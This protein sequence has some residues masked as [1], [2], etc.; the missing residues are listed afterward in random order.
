MALKS[1]AGVI[2][3][4]RKA[5]VAY[6]MLLPSMAVLFAF[7]YFPVIS[8]IFHSFTEWDGYRP[9]RFIGM[10]N[11]VRMATDPNMLMS[12]RN[13]FVFSFGHLATDLI[14]SVGVALLIHELGGGRKSRF[15]QTIFIVPIMVPT[16]ITIFIWKFIYDPQFGL[17]NSLLATLGLPAQNF[18]AD[19][20]FAIL[21]L[22]FLG[23]PWIWGPGVLMQLAGLQSIP[24]T[25]YDAVAIE[26]VSWGR[27]IWTFDIPLIAPQIRVLSML[28]LIN[29]LQ[30]FIYQLVLTSGGPGNSTFVPGF[31][32][33]QQGVKFGRMGYACAI[34]VF[35][36]VV[37][38]LLSSVVRR[39]GKKTMENAQ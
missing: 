33:Y 38:L 20:E 11:Y 39:I 13:M 24:D 18:L 31:L 37:I 7:L 23:F 36:L 16:I 6:A 21:W 26:G 30:A 19:P 15:Y 3:A 34:G 9:A 2:R 32:L 35:L 22:V 4:M 27:R 5:Q 1:T 25:I 28:S 29:S 8:S 10:D 12:I 17:G 14:T